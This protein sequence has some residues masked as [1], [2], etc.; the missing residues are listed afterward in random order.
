MVF[1]NQRSIYAEDQRQILNGHTKLA[2]MM[3]EMGKVN[4][5]EKESCNREKTRLAEIY[6]QDFNVQGELGNVEL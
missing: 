4:C 1:E 3:T 5:V 6:Y 2:E